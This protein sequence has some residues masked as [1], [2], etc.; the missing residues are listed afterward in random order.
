[1][2]RGRGPKKVDQ[3]KRRRVQRNV[4]SKKSPSKRT[5]TTTTFDDRG[6]EAGIARAST[7]TRADKKKS[8]EQSIGSIDRRINEA[9]KDNNLD[10]VKDL[11]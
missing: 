4:R 3:A 9:L 7:T 6:R 1:M 8:L 11:R 5:T 10:L 2:P